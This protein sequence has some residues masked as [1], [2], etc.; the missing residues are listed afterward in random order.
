MPSLSAA[1][2]GY[3]HQDCITACALATILLPKF[4]GVKVTVDRKVIAEDCFDDLELSGKERSRIQIKSHESDYRPLLLSDFTTNRISFR[5]DKA[6]RSFYEDPNPANSYCLF[7][8][9]DSPEAELAPYLFTTPL[10]APLLP[11]FATERYKLI[12]EKIWPE[13]TVPLWPHV[14]VFGRDVFSCVFVN[15]SL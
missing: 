2:F 13:S 4:E 14:D 8:S 6:I 9:Y 12:P 10:I 3:N 1:H 7:T 11:C 5:I 15:G